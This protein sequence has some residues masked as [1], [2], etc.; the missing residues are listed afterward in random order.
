M[1]DIT[2]Q[3]VW[4]V[5]LSACDLSPHMSV[6]SNL[7]AHSIRYGVPKTA[8]KCRA[9]PVHRWRPLAMP[10]WWHQVSPTETGLDTPLRWPTCLWTSCTPSQLLKSVTCLRL[11]S[12]YAL[13]FIQVKRNFTGHFLI[14]LQENSAGHEIDHVLKCWNHRWTLPNTKL[15]LS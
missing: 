11:K 14:L 3:E 6:S 4:M 9:C 13:D 8:V 1:F 7:S 10:T 2:L 12:K 5:S 15:S